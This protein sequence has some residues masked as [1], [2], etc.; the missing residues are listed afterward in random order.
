MPAV[1]EHAI[2]V[3]AQDID[4][5]G[6]AGNLRY[7]EWMQQAAVFHSAAQGW[8]APRYTRAGMWWVVRSHYIKYLRPAFDGDEVVVMTWVYNFKRSSSLRKYRFT[9]GEDVLAV[10]ETNWALVDTTERSPVRIPPDLRAAF[11]VVEME[12]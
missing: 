3:A 10:A 1:F 8:D 5:Q 6:H 12:P 2:R 7:V 9:R 11:D 4:A